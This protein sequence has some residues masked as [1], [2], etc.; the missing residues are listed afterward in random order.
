M[1]SNGEP[2]YR[3]RYKEIIKEQVVLGYLT[4]GGVSYED[5]DHM[6]PYERMLSLEAIQDYLTEQNEA[7][8]K[9]FESAR[10]GR[11]IKDPKSA[12]TSGIKV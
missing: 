9:A 7:Q 3:A 5:S 8:K 1:T 6:T 4:R 12:L 10:G 11:T 2:Y